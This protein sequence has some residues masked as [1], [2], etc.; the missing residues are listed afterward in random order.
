MKVLAVYNIKG[1]VGKTAASVNL[2]YLSA[3]AGNRTLLCDLDPQGSSSYYFRVRP[4]K[5]HGPK[6][7]LQGGKKLDREI[8]ES[9][10]PNLHLL[11]SAMAYRN[12]DIELDHSKRSKKRLKD[13]LKSLVGEYDVVVIDSPPNVTLLSENIF[14][15]ADV[16]L[17][18][19]IPTTLSM[20]TYGQIIDFFKKEGLKT[21]KLRAFFSMVERRKKM[22]Q[23]TMV[24]MR[25][26]DKRFLK[27]EI[28]MAAAVEKMGL[29]REPL[30]GFD[31]RSVA[32][33]AYRDLW[34]DASILLKEA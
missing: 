27:P 6:R 24:Q 30:F 32:A 1:G 19:V 17:V 18:P 4:D 8:R 31:S 12:L 25:K 3:Q 13:S 2:A 34:D 28:P 7:L 10:Y 15:A 22:H 26:K 14:R 20:L 23:D 21:Q 33:K 11:P 16:I 29:H 9:D 5:K